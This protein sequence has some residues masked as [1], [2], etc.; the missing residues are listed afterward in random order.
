MGDTKRTSGGQGLEARPK[1]TTHD[2][3]RTSSQQVA[4]KEWRR[5]QSKT[6]GGPVA[7]KDWGRGQSQPSGGHKADKRRTRTGGTSKGNNT[8]GGHWPDKWRTRSGGA[9]KANNTTQGGQVADKRRTSGEQVA[10]KEWRRGQS[11]QGGQ[12]ADTSR[13]HG[14]Q[15]LGTRPEHIAASLSFPKREPHSK[16]FGKTKKNAHFTPRHKSENEC[17]T[18]CTLFCW[19]R[20]TVLAGP[21][22]E[23]AKFQSR[24][25]GLFVS[26][27][28]ARF[29]HTHTPGTEK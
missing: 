16:L 9:A 2:K 25:Y 12:A 21:C 15:A 23:S 5:G 7:D 3:R 20:D 26:A 6:Q 18:V 29:S 22:F 17:A 11:Q 27:L 28:R 4:D 19:D 13:T 8:M 24:I 10:D 1:P 14:G